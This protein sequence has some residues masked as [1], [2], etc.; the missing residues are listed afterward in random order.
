MPQ[1]DRAQASASDTEARMKK[2]L[3]EYT[4]AGEESMTE[5]ASLQG[6]LN[7]SS[8]D[9]VDLIVAF[10]DEFGI[11]V[12]DADIWGLATVGDVRA[13]IEKALQAQ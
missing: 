1:N 13:Y 5:T 8:L 9:V 3:K 6:D 10:E 7:L 4:A 12:A 11:E 2:I